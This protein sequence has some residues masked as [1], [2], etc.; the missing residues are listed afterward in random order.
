[1]NKEEKIV[2]CYRRMYLSMVK[3]DIASLDEILS[4]DFVLVHMTGSKQPK[5]AFLES[6]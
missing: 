2:E 1:M 3:R 6:G 4:D 5:A